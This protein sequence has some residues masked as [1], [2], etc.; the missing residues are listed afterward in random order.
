MLK[1]KTLYYSQHV[2]QSMTRRGI[3]KNI[4]EVV[5]RNG[6]WSRGKKEYSFEVEYKGVIVIL[7]E[8][9][10]QYN[11]G[12]C[13]LNRENTIKVEQIKED[14]GISFWKAIHTVVKGIDFSEEI[15]KLS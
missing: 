5:V 8:Q 10:N 2:L 6:Y 14:R 9:K 11:V 13:K 12:T 3:S 7:Y 15:D 4:I 1:E